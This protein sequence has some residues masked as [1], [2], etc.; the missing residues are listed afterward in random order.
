MSDGKN[1][2]R[3]VS[4]KPNL[5]AEVEQARERGEG[6]TIMNCSVQKSKKLRCDALEIVV[7][8][9]TN[10]VKSPKK[11]ELTKMFVVHRLA[12]SVQCT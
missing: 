6:V 7:G 1:M 10:V 8:K 5:R 4:F 2:V 11:F 3:M 12:S 9:H